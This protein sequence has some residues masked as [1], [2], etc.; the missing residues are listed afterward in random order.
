MFLFAT[1]ILE[2]SFHDSK[3]SIYID[4]CWYTYFSFLIV[5]EHSI[6][7]FKERKLFYLYYHHIC[8]FIIDACW[9]R[10]W[11]TYF[12]VLNYSRTFNLL[13]QLKE[14]ILL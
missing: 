6:F 7:C 13:L 14:N 10:C 3:V 8:W 11:V 12:L 5:Q 9:E 1:V 2:F 4:T